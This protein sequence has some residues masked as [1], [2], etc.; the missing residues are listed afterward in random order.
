MTVRGAG[1]ENDPKEGPG[2]R[3]GPVADTANVSGL[4][5]G[6]VE[7]DFGNQ[8]FAEIYKVQHVVCHWK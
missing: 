7:A 8:I 6:C 3:P 2:C 4:V 5:L 1:M